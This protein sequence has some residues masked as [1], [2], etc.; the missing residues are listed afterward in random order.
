M[1]SFKQFLSESE[2]FDFEKFKKD[3][4]EYLG[5]LK[6]THGKCMLYRGARYAPQDYHIEEWKEREG[7]RDSSL[8][9]HDGINEYLED[10]F[11]VPARDWMFCTGV[12]NDAAIY[13][14]GRKDAMVI[15]PIGDF[16]WLAATDEDARDMT[17]F[18]NRCGGR[19]DPTYDAPAITEKNKQAV[20]IMKHKM[21][22]W[23]WKD[24]EDIVGCI[25]SD[26]EI[27]FRCDKFYAF[28][29]TGTTYL[30]QEFKDFLYS[31]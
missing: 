10:K 1:I 22:K 25:K 15:F 3:C 12:Y 13:S 11:G 5:M 14:S 2:K 9:M 28:N 23:H 21:E 18:Y 27:M 30:S 8:T 4:S 29:Y 7:P 24:S 17:G 20:E 6:G 19:K 26:N 31:I 16:E